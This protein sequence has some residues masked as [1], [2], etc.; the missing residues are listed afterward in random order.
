[1]AALEGALSEHK[2]AS[3]EHRGS[4]GAPK[5][6]APQEPDLAAPYP[7][8]AALVVYSTSVAQLSRLLPRLRQ[9]CRLLASSCTNEILVDEGLSL[10]IMGWGSRSSHFEMAF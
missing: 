7:A 6:L 10:G 2:G 3:R 4:I 1:M 9:H 8:I 5:V